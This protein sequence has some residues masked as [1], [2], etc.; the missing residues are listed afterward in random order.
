MNVW[1]GVGNLGKNNDVKFGQSGNAV[2]NQSLAVKRSFKDKQTGEYAT[3]WI[4]LV[5]FGKTAEN[6]ANFTKKGS[7]VGIEGRIQT[8]SYENNQGQRVYTT[9]V[10]VNQFHLLDPKQ[11][12]SGGQGNQQVNNQSN[13]QTGYN[14]QKNDGFNYNGDSRM[15][16]AQQVTVQ[17]D[18]LPF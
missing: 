18:S 3:D 4:N 1:N 2:L 5:M 7:R 17:D 12:N 14:A 11:A 8:G 15:L 9:D 6:F 13:K 10:I 16:E